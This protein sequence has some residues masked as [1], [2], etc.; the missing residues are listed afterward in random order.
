MSK[1][2]LPAILAT[3]ALFACSHAPS[4]GP[5][6]DASAATNRALHLP[7]SGSVR[8][9]PGPQRQLADFRLQT[10]C[11]REARAWV[12]EHERNEDYK[13]S[14]IEIIELD[15]THYSL[16]K[17]GCYAVVDDRSTA[18]N[19]TLFGDDRRLYKV[20]GGWHG[21]AE[22]TGGTRNP[23]DGMYGGRSILIHGM[24]LCAVGERKCRSYV[25]WEALTRPYLQD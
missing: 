23:T 4:P 5:Q 10:A 12:N 8:A 13:P 1:Y 18:P 7:A 24:K 22:I 3:T 21:I 20:D 15:Q 2:I 16:I 17:H 9:P 11:A 6:A 25:E 14:S 19:L